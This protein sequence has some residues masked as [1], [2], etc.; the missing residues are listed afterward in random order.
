MNSIELKKK[1]VITGI[2]LLTKTIMRVMNDP[3][4]PLEVI[5]SISSISQDLKGAQEKICNRNLSEE[6]YDKCLIEIV[7]IYA[8][9]FKDER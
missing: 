8:L 4:T 5:K 9:V 7:D 2:D 3:E 6:D 1:K